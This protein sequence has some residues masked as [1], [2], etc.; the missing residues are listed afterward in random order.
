[1]TRKIK[2]CKEE[3]CANQQTTAGFCRLH[4]LKNWKKIRTE[5]KKKAAKGIERY[6]QSVLRKD[7]DRASLQLKKSLKDETR[8]NRAVDEQMRDDS[9]A[10]AMHELA[11]ST[12]FDSI[13]NKSISID[14]NF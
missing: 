5:K 14:E 9:L 7:P 4:Y 3:D 11:Y 8:L 2:L 1:M 6:I 12:D 10:N 13:I